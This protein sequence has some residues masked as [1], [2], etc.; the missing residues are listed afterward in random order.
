[1]EIVE[2]EEIAISAILLAT[3]PPVIVDVEIVSEG[4]MSSYYIIRADG[5]SKRYSI[6]TLLFQDID[7]KDLENLWKIIKGKFKDADKVYPLTHA[8]IT[9]MLDR[10]LQVDHQNEMAYQLLKLMLKQLKK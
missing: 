6:M 8:T 7:R 5:K 4:Q 9:K 1:M 3:K 2:V 10:K